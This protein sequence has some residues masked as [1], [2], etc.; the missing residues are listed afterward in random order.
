ML[1]ICIDINFSKWNKIISDANKNLFPWP[2]FHTFII[3]DVLYIKKYYKN[4]FK[5]TVIE[6]MLNF[7]INI[8]L[9][10]VHEIINNNNNGEN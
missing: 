1:H 5:S 10:K 9:S 3:M 2:T 7:G 6:R 4:I 8:N